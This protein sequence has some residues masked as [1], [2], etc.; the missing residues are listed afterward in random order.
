MELHGTHWYSFVCID[1]HELSRGF[2]CNVPIEFRMVS[3]TESLLSIRIF[4]FDLVEPVSVRLE[5]TKQMILEP[6][7]DS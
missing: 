4:V 5:S 2:S 6:E 1:P 7:R 3:E